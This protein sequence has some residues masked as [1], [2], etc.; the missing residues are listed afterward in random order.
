MSLKKLFIILLPPLLAFS[1]CRPDERCTE[2]ELVSWMENLSEKSLRFESD[3][4]N[5]VVFNVGKFKLDQQEFYDCASGITTSCECHC[6]SS[7]SLLGSISKS[8]NS[9]SGNVSIRL[10]REDD[11]D[12]NLHTNSYSIR[13]LDLYFE[14][15][16]SFFNGSNEKLELFQNAS[17]TVS[18]ENVTKL[19]GSKIEDTSTFIYLSEPEGLVGFTRPN[20]D[21]YYLI[22]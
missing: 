14:D 6:E 3:S 2:L 18:Y 19:S 1:C 17:K 22:Q 9:L 8:S 20:G 12:N 7:S 21:T 4:G 16:T 15:V 13:V 11:V 5:W 10:N